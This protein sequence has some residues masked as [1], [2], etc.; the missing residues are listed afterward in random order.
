MIFNFDTIIDRRKTNSLKFDN[1]DKTLGV[2]P[3]AIPMWVADMDF[4][5]AP[6]IADALRARMEHRVLG[7][8]LRTES[9]AE[10]IVGWQKRRNGWVVKP[11]WV[12][13][14]PGVVAG[15]AVAI[16]QFTKPGE[17]VIVQTPVYHPF[18]LTV[19]ALGRE[20]AYNSLL[21]HRQYA[22]IDF[23]DLELKA[24]TA[25]M[26][27]LCNPHNPGGRVWTRA[28]LARI[29]DICS[30]NGVMVVS[31]EIHSDLVYKPAV[32]TPYASI[33]D[34]SAQKSLTLSAPSKTFNIAGLATSYVVAPNAEILKRYNAGL[35]A[36]HIGFGNLFGNVA[37]EA[38][39]NGGDEWVD[40]L[41]SYLKGN[42][43]FAIGY[44]E[45]NIPQMH[46]VRPEATFL[47]WCD[48]REFN[49]SE[50]ELSDF[51]AHRAKVAVNMGSMFGQ[52]GRGFVRLNIG[53]PRATLETALE[54]IKT[55]L[56]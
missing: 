20:V 6:C 39:Y 56:P 22:Q 50:R 37:L 12:G 29:A 40:Q 25:K 3:D 1:I 27:L 7:Y 55:A 9:F 47:L 34:A 44:A 18:F 26:L 10:S 35:D 46:I 38:A 15:I 49:M 45:K 51:F 41:I 36:M 28:E 54:R 30:R 53:C 17:K 23:D 52:E 16:S 33:S 14:S 11:E 5:V 19:K 2:A 21:N 48:C 42:V 4:A 32:F 13:F 31:D 24:R 43:D 8:T